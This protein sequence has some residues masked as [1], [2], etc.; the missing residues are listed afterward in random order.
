[1]TIWEIILVA[2]GLSLDV[3]AVVVLYSAMLVRIE[4]RKLASMC[5]IFAGW[6]M[7]AVL[8]GTLIT[9]LPFF[10]MVSTQVEHLWDVISVVI[11]FALGAYMLYKAGKHEVVFE[12]RSEINYKKVCVAALITSLDA[13]FAGIGTGFLETGLV[14]ELITMAVVTILTVI[15][16][17]Y[18]GYRLGWEQKKKANGLGGVILIAAGVDVIIRYLG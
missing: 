4:K 11:F 2:I 5:L 3:Y 15:L 17:M 16:G 10:K 9:H 13:F 12:H 7:L 14:T 1:M 8:V 18:T 6:Q